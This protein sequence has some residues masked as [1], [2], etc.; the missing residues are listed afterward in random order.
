MHVSLHTLT[1]YRP[2]LE[3]DVGRA[4]LGLFDELNAG[5]GEWAARN[6]C[7]LYC[8]LAAEGCQTVGQWLWRRICYEE[9]PYAC[10]VAEGRETAGLDAAARRDLAI[11][12][13]LSRLDWQGVKERIAKLC[14]PDWQAELA[15]L[16]GWPESEGISF[17]AAQAFYRTHGT[18]ELA[19]YRA[20]KWEKNRLIPVEQPDFVPETELW[21]YQLQRDK[22]A[23]NTRALVEGRRVNNVLLFGE[24]GT[25]KSATVKALLGMAGLEKLRLIEVSKHDLGDLAGLM[26]RLGSRPQKFILFIDDLSFDGEDTTYSVL[27]SLLEGG[28]EPRPA[29]VAVYA[30]SNRRTLV[31]QNF[32][33][34]SGD[35]VDARET[36]QEKTSLAERFGLRIAYTS[37]TRVQFLTMVEELARLRGMDVPREVLQ[38]EAVKWEMRHSSRTP[39]TAV[40]FLD[41]LNV[42]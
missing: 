3:L 21:G 36:V 11:L 32:S 39:R 27:K 10:A 42:E 5:H 8:A 18:G 7:R 35:E 1:L 13:K 6:Y 4:L 38:A 12:D 25:G 22:V 34:R 40:Q 16:P 17:E 19:R 37:L 41:S 2:L 33:H 23:A 9:T 30:T 15:G 31:R 20:F 24:P 29:N 26:R 14:S 28:L